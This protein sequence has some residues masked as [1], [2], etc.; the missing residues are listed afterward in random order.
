[1]FK[2]MGI[3]LAGLLVFAAFPALADEAEDREALLLELENVNANGLVGAAQIEI[4]AKSLITEFYERRGFEPAWRDLDQIDELLGV[5]RASSAEGLNPDDYHL[6][7]VAAARDQMRADPAIAAPDRA[8]I[9]LM[10]TDSLIRLGYHQLFGKANPYSL[11]TNWNFRRE[12]NLDDLVGV[13]ENAIES[14]SLAESLQQLVPRGWLYRDLMAA[15]ARYRDIALRGGWPQIPEGQTLRPGDSDPRTRIIAARLAVTGDL[16][17]AQSPAAASTA[18]ADPLV[19]AVQRFQERHGIEIDGIVGANPHAILK[20]EV[21]G[22]DGELQQWTAETTSPS[23]LRRRGWSQESFKAGE[24]ITL[25]GM[26]SLDGSYLIRIT[27][28]FHEDGSEIGVP[29]GTDN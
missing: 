19:A 14:R 9:D 18:Y 17:P 13:I 8:A 5:I 20:F 28:A 4:A 15:L 3:L 11:D 16:D 10:L 26:P 24:K 2:V 23:I 6:A 12:L 27:R 7:A 29:R 1:M 25:E 21:V 22:D